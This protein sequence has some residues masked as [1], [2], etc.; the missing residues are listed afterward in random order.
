MVKKFVFVVV[1]FVLFSNWFSDIDV[2]ILSFVGKPNSVIN[3]CLTFFDD[4]KFC[5]IELLKVLF[6]ESI[7]KNYVKEELESYKSLTKILS[8]PYSKFWL[9]AERIV[10]Q[11]CVI[12]DVCLP[13]WKK[14]IS[15]IL[16]IFIKVYLT[17]VLLFYLKAHL[18]TY[19]FVPMVLRC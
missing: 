19:R 12:I 8:K 5:E 17:F 2:D 16:K 10:K 3:V 18:K 4:E 1:L 7:Y 6:V 9:I 11:I 15:F 13:E 14:I